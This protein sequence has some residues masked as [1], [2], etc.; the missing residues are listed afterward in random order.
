MR[1]LSARVTLIALVAFA[2][3][4]TDLYLSGIPGI[5]ADLGVGH[6]E[7]QLT[8]SLFMVGFAA[9]QL[10]FGP[11]SDYHGRKPV[12]AVGLWLYALATLL[13]ALAP[14]ITTLLGARLL[15]GLAAAS[16]PVIARAIVRDRYRARCRADDGAARRGHGLVPLFAP[17]LGSWLLYCFDWRAQFAGMLLFGLATLAGLRTLVESCPRSGSGRSTSGACSAVR[18]LPA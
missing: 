17:V 5:V 2:A 11:L 15:Q 9:G 18:H 10:L 14:S 6:A 12:V 7:G 3:V 13:C 4:S 16:G 8:L 1:E